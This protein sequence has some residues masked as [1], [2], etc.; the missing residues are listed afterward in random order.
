LR[1]RALHLTTD[2]PPVAEPLEVFAFLDGLGAELL[3]QGALY[4]GSSGA[5]VRI[6]DERAVRRWRTGAW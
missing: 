4:D 1:S 2:Q 3:G 5:A 6:I